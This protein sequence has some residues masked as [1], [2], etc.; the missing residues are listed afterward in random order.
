MKKLLFALTLSIAALATGITPPVV[1]ALT[2]AEQS[3][4][5]LKLQDTSIDCTKSSSITDSGPVNGLIRTIINT[6]SIIV[7]T[8]SVI[9]III[10]GFRY[11]ISGGDSSA[12]KSAK[13]TILYAVI[14]LV[15]VIFAQVIV[16]FVITNAIKKPAPPA[17][18]KK[19]TYSQVVPQV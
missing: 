5:A 7:G 14:G 19:T 17:P 12:T 1:A 16:R 10:G 13:D 18:P 4:Q 8:I 2:P 9:M 15:V 6:L 11:V 3:C